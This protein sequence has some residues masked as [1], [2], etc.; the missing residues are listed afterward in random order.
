MSSVG[1]MLIDLAFVKFKKMIIM[2]LIRFIK[3]AGMT[4]E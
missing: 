3:M 2:I 1:L 4:L